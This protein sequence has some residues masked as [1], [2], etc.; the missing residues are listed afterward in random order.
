MSTDKFKTYLRQ[1]TDIS[2]YKEPPYIDPITDIKDTSVALKMINQVDPES[3]MYKIDLYSPKKIFL[4]LEK[5]AMRELE[6]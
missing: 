6:K 3:R 5:K 4:M 1:F 2:D